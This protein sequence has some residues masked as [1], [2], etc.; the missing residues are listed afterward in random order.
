M[1]AEVVLKDY[2]VA[3]PADDALRTE[4]ARQAR[5]RSLGFWLAAV[6]AL[7]FFGLAS[8]SFRM[9]HDEEGAVAV[10]G[11]IVAVER[12][13]RNGEL[14]MTTEFVDADGKVHRDT[15]PEG[16]HYASGEPKVA[17]GIE[18]VYWRSK[19]T[20][21]IDSHPRNDILVKWA[22]GSAGLVLALMALGVS[23]Y[24]NRHRRLRLRLLASGRR[25]RG[26]R[27]AIEAKTTVIALK[28]THIIHQW[29]LNARYFEDSL[30]AFKDCHS[31]W[32]PGL[33]P[34][35]LDNLTVP[36][37]LVDAADPRRYWLPVGELHER[38]PGTT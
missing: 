20:G 35:R 34:E 32:Q 33:P 2:A 31:D 1:S 26:A 8:F 22:F 12:D 37:I 16:Y 29:R 30:T 19:Y 5:S 23:V 18:Y 15:L 14:L 3:M 11:T 17:Q 21:E 38:R 25:E 28:V 4:I 24:M 13:T 27:Y 9:M 7:I 10:D 36:M 6:F